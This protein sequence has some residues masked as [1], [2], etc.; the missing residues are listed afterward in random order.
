MFVKNSSRF[1]QIASNKGPKSNVPNI[2]TFYKYCRSW[3][4]YCA[5][6]YSVVYT[7]WG[8]PSDQIYLYIVIG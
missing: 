7:D 8:F 6:A 4:C 3:N 1:H 2:I 5:A